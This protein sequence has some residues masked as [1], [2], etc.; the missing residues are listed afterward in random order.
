[1]SFDWFAFLDLAELLGDPN[2]APLTNPEA[3]RRSS[4][5]RAYFAIFCGVRD[6]CSKE[7]N[8]KPEN[9]YADHRALRDYLKKQ[10]YSQLAYLLENL[11]RYR[12][13]A[14][15][16]TEM[17]NASKIRKKAVENARAAK[18]IILTKNLQ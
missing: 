12:N 10:R 4:I 2:T 14:D 16:N 11:R 1:M 13:L 3:E 7:L 8:Y 6:F 5:S 9:T 15:Y 18:S 17:K